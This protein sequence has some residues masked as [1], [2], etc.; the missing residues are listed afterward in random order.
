MDGED[1]ECNLCSCLDGKAV[2]KD[3]SKNKT[4]DVHKYLN[5]N[6]CNDKD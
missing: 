1:S 5:L 4:K 3:R 6:F 2:I